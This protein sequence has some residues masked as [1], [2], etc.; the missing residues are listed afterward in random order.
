MV[1]ASP[2]LYLSFISLAYNRGMPEVID[3]HPSIAKFIVTLPKDLRSKVNLGLD[4]IEKYGE[5]IG[6]PDARKIEG[7]LYEFRI[8]GETQIRILYS[9]IGDAAYI[10]HVFIK[11]SEKLPH[12][13]L[14]LVQKRL[15]SLQRLLVDR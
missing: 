10:L 6:F 8:V 15:R 5:R 3:T 14:R 11:K 2:C 4:A 7:G 13:E 1:K 12:K 9:V